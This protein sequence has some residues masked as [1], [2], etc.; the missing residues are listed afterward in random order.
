MPGISR[1]SIDA[2]LRDFGYF[3]DIGVINR[4]LKKAPGMGGHGGGSGSAPG[5]R[6]DLSGKGGDMVERVKVPMPRGGVAKIFVG[7]LDGIFFVIEK[8]SQ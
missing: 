7:I 4:N 8:N 1:I 2:V 5:R 3:G 6:V